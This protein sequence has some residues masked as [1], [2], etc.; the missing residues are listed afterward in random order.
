MSKAKRSLAILGL[1][2]TMAFVD[3]ALAQDTG[4]YVGGA[5]GQ[6]S[7]D[8]EC[9]PTSTSC[10]E[11]DS[12]WKIF[13][14]YQFNRH[15]AVELGYSDLGEVSETE[16][17]ILG[18]VTGALKATVWDLVA[19]ASMPIA[20]GFSIFGKVGL[21]RADT[22]F[23]A[24]AIG[25]SVT[26]S[27][28]NTDLTFG[29]GARYDFTRNLGVRLEWQRYQ[30]VGGTFFGVDVEGDVDVISVALIGKF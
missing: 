17:T 25:L 10:D 14:G 13:G 11:E 21:Y 20:D 19:V 12:S 9:S 24:S 1:T 28:S 4:F 27:D 2:S 6:T 7:V 16:P 26:E 8:L 29:V 3:P 18:N 30:D 5:L 23:T 22:D 15:F